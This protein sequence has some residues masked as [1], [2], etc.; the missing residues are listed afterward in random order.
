MREWVS[1]YQESQLNKRKIRGKL[2]DLKSKLQAIKSDFSDIRKD[3]SICRSMPTAFVDLLEEMPK[4]YES[5]W[6]S[7]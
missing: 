3:I 2:N 7:K 5:M 4:V 1:I 6:E